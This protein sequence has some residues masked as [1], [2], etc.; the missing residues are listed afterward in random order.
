M[1]LIVTFVTALIVSIL[2]FRF[3]NLKKYKLKFLALMLWGAF[4]MV[5]VDHAIGWLHGGE[6]IE[7]TTDGLILGVLMVIPL[8]AVWAAAVSTKFGARI[9]TD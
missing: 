7:I 1:W 2:H 4:I 9:C 3:N 6:F 8:I 5:L